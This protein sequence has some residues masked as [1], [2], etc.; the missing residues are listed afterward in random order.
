MNARN[1]I[2]D[3]EEE[4]EC[5]EKVDKRSDECCRGLGRKAREGNIC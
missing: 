2:T 4:I 1:D 5:R 3:A